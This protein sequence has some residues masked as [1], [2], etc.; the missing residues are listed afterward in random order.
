MVQ[1]VR[2]ETLV[3]LV[4]LEQMATQ[5]LMATGVMVALLVMQAILV[6]AAIT[7][8]EETVAHGV[9][10]VTREILVIQETLEAMVTAAAAV[11]EET[12]VA[13]VMVV[14]LVVAPIPPLLAETLVALTEIET[15]MVTVAQAGLVISKC[16]EMPMLVEAELEGAV[17]AVITV[18]AAQAEIQGQTEMLVT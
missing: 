2:A 16:L 17:A 14:L 13:A 9:T 4:M 12:V 15:P 7:V 5:E 3:F 1:V 11:L 10:Q 6:I 8:F 18:V